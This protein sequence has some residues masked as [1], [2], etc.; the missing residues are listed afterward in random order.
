MLL[1]KRLQDALNSWEKRCF[2]LYIS[3]SIRVLHNHRYT[4]FPLYGA[5]VNS[6]EFR[7]YL[8]QIQP[9]KPDFVYDR[10]RFR[11]F[12]E[13]RE[14]TDVFSILPEMLSMWTWGGR[15]V[16]ELSED[17]THVFYATSLKNLQWK[18]IKFPLPSFAISLGHPI[19]G[20]AGEEFD[21]IIVSSKKDHRGRT[22]LS[23]YLLAKKLEHVKGEVTNEEMRKLNSLLIDKNWEKLIKKFNS[24]YSR[25]EHEK[26][27]LYSLFHIYP[28]ELGK[29]LV[30]ESAMAQVNSVA[31]KVQMKPVDPRK[32]Q[33]PEWDSALRIVIALTKYLQTFPVP[34]R[35]KSEEE[36]RLGKALK[37]SPVWITREADVCLLSNQIK[38]TEE[39]RVI[40]RSYIR[41][42][43]SEAAT[44]IVQG[45]GRRP[46][47]FGT[48]RDYPRSEWVSPYIWGLATFVADQAIGGSLKSL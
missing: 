15:R 27:V 20:A 43:E 12:S 37:Q 46:K 26:S 48:I 29:T 9:L 23:F 13:S 10:Q 32:E 41:N 28:D 11:L 22:M 44:R 18:D 21:T 38:L 42:P 4:I 2:M 17:F 35:I 3:S 39:A 25:T 8:M 36:R 33:H 40:F 6:R 5:I 45:Y 16:Y 34:E 19:Y 24:I 7:K 14:K 31:H 47:G 1:A 30:T